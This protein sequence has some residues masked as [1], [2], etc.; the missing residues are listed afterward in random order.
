MHL[1]RSTRQEKKS[2]GKVYFE[3]WDATFGVKINIYHADNGIFSGKTFRSQ[4]EYFNQKITFCG[5]GYHHQ[6]DIIEREIKTLTIE[7]RK[8]LPHAKIYWTEAITTMLWPYALKAF[9]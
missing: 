7:A 8:L 2:A 9:S 1:I 3:G 6:N 5:V 4:I